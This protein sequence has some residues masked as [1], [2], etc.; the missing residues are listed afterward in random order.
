MVPPKIIKNVFLNKY[1]SFHS[2][3]D[4]EVYLKTKIAEAHNISNDEGVSG[5]SDPNGLIQNRPLKT[6]LIKSHNYA[7]EGPS[8]QRSVRNDSKVSV[9]YTP[10]DSVDQ[11]HQLQLSPMHIN[12]IE[13]NLNTFGDCLKPSESM[14]KFDFDMHR[15]EANLQKEI[16]RRRRRHTI[17]CAG[18]SNIGGGDDDDD[19]MMEVTRMLNGSNDDDTTIDMTINLPQEYIRLNTLP[20]RKKCKRIASTTKDM[21]YSLENVFDPMAMATDCKLY[22]INL[23]NKT[24]D[25]ASETQ[26]TS[27]TSDSNSSSNNMSR[28]KNGDLF[29]EQ[30]QAAQSMLEL[31]KEGLID[32][33]TS[34]SMPNISKTEQLTKEHN[35]VDNNTAIVATHTIDTAVDCEPKLDQMLP[36]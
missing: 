18:A 14:C 25:E 17:L 30:R 33:Q 3:A 35:H 2:V 12:F 1:I 11:S 20:K 6:K 22:D 4:F 13:E 19:E 9:Y 31:I 26:M 29:E 10:N 7:I 8:T 21:Y 28:S 32:V 36:K 27:S 34:N 5:Y 16:N 23:S 24:I 15:M